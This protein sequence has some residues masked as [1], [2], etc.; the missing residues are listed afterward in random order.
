MHVSDR[1]IRHVHD[2]ICIWIRYLGYLG[3]LGYPVSGVPRLGRMEGARGVDEGQP[4]ATTRNGAPVMLNTYNAV[5]KGNLL[6]WRGEPPP[7]T[8]EERG[9]S[10]QVT[11][12]RGDGSSPQLSPDAGERM[13]V[14][15]EKLAEGGGVETIED[16]VAWQR[17]TRRDRALPGRGDG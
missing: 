15:L 17:E 1:D 8:S 2:G 13:A 12:L 14:A 5:L 10:V 16:P 3:Y 11:V 9:V 4:R 7:E 6:E